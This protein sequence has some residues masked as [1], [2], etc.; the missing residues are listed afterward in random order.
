M[1]ILYFLSQLIFVWIFKYSK[2]ARD[3]IE[4]YMEEIK[5]VGV[6]G[7]ISKAVEE[8]EA[9]TS[10]NLERHAS[11]TY[12]SGSRRNSETPEENRSFNSD[13]TKD[14]HSRHYS[15]D[16]KDDIQWSGQDSTRDH[17]RQ[18]PNRNVVSVRYDRDDHY[19]SRGGKQISSFSKEQGYVGQ[20]KDLDESA[21]DYSRR[22][23]QRQNEARDEKHYKR[24]RDEHVRRTHKRE[25]DEHERTS[26]KR[27][28]DED[29]GGHDGRRKS[30]AHRNR[31]SSRE[32]REFGDRYDPAAS[33]H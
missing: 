17:G 3:I 9:L 26:R 12:V 14:L 1:L 7:G 13:Y 21:E 24:S 15:G 4:E 23:H 2:V 19:G 30:K 22:S 5:Q 20:K 31:S 16:P 33:H 27:E 11:A 25:K 6:V 28:R 8:K 10:E 18:Y 32:L 29:K